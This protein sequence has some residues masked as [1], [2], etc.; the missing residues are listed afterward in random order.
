MATRELPGAYISLND[1]SQYPEG[2]NSLIVGYVV[3]AKRGAVN[4][5]GLVTSPTDFLTKYTLT[6]APAVNDDPTFWSILKV[7]S[8]TNQ[9]Y[10]VRA[11]NNPIYGGV[12]IKKPVTVGALTAAVKET[13][14]LTVTGTTAPVEGTKL[15]IKG[16]GTIDG[17]YT[18]ASAELQSPNISIVVKEDLVA[19][20]TLGAKAAYVYNAPIVPLEEGLEDP[21]NYEFKADDLML[22][23]G[24]DAGAYNNDIAFDIVSSI[25][26]SSQ[27]VYPNTMKLVVKIAS[28]N[29]TLETFEFSRKQDAKTIDGT[30]LYVDSVVKGSAYIKVRNNTTLNGVYLPNS[31]LAG[32]P[33]ACAGGT[34]GEAVTTETLVGA[35]NIFA[36]KTIP[37][38][39]LGNGCS[40][41]AENEIFQ[42]AMIAL[43]E[44]RK[45]LIVFLSNRKEDESATLNSVKAQN[46]VDYKKSTLASTSFYST[47]YAP[48]AN[49]TDTFN[50]RTVKIG[51][52]A[53][54]IAGWLDVIN[55]LNYPYAYAGPQNGL[56][57]GVTFDWK[58][59]D[60][61]GEAQLLNDA[62][63]NYAAYDGRVGR[64]YM[65]CQN[66]LQIANSSLRN[67]GCVFNLLDLKRSMA[68]FLKEYGQLPITN[69]LRRD[70]LNKANNFLS[71]MVGSRFYNVSFQDV[72]TEADLAQDTLRYFMYIDLTRYAQRIYVYMNIVNSTFDWTMVQ[73]A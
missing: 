52:D 35:L 17:L 37:I 1:L 63:V 16:T 15:M 69:T 3:K 21:N 40:V 38:D 23:T 44:D 54:A 33:I 25:D 11:A 67:L 41:E 49:Y 72:T 47:M 59:G 13:K 64:Y 19:D 66:T 26:N 36:N 28:T 53:I 42:Q 48:H 9:V 39:I 50:S 55:N 30:S 60:E 7:L 70:I 58:I 5:A 45:D 73:S 34:D 56:V 20:F 29:T 6:G 71:P 61:G 46:V 51:C 31:T 57:S 2:A 4:Q 22:I 10:V 68:T 65:Q 32:S 62:S 14:T 43:A 12:V 27:L 18:V 8:K 24:I